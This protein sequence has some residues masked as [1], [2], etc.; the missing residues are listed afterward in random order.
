MVAGGLLLSPW[1]DLTSSQPSILTKN[2]DF[3]EGPIESKE[4]KGYLFIDK[5]LMNA[6]ENL[7]EEIL[8]NGHFYTTEKYLKCP[9]VSPMYQDK[10]DRFPPIIITVGGEER[11]ED[12]VIVFAHKIKGYNQSRPNSSSIT[13]HIY[14][15]MIHVFQA[16]ESHPSSQKSFE[17]SSEFIKDCF[18]NNNE[19]T[20]GFW[21]YK[22]DVKQNFNPVEYD[23]LKYNVAKPFS[24]NGEA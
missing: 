7:K 5:L 18:N 11:F 6:P 22:V 24:F 10:F 4:G 13:L 9:L 14:D 16:L 23:I 8:N 12:E 15:E 17:L 20:N 19:D 21:A 2:N 3:F 1:V